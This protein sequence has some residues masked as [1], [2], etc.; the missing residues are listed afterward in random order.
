MKFFSIYDKIKKIEQS[1]ILKNINII[2]VINNEIL[3]NQDVAIIDGIIIEIGDNLSKKYPNIKKIDCT[4]KYLIPSLSD[5]NVNILNEKDYLINLMFGVMTLRVTNGNSYLLDDKKMID[6]S[7][8]I[9]PDLF[10]GSPMLSSQQSMNDVVI[11]VRDQ[12]EALKYSRDYISKGYKFMNI[13]SEINSDLYLTI[14]DEC[15]SYGFRIAANLPEKIQIGTAIRCGQD[16]IDGIDQYITNIKSYDDIE[17]QSQYNIF[18]S[19]NIFYFKKNSKRQ[20]VLLGDSYLKY[21][22]KSV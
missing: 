15:K 14:A 4:G 20:N 1:E 9:G 10:V 3:K 11:I 8:I 19:P 21:V 2:D 6:S 13:S 5:M 16:I 17:Y 7:Q 18:C 12:F 22:D